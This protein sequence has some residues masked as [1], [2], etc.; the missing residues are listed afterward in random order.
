[1]G[2]PKNYYG[3]AAAI[4]LISSNSFATTVALGP[5]QDVTLYEDST[6]QL[7]NGAGE[8]IFAG[9]VG[10]NTAGKLRRA[11]IKFDVSAIPASATITSV[12]LAMVSVQGNPPTQNSLHRVF[13]SWGEGTS[14]AGGNEGGGTTA[15]LNDATWTSR[16]FGTP[17]NWATPGGDFTAAATT[18][19]TVAS[20]GTTTWSGGTIVNDVQ[21]WVAG[22]ATNFGWLL[23]GDETVMSTTMRYD[24]RQNSTVASRPVLTVIYTPVGAICDWER[25]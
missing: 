23:Q 11:L 8:G 9:R 7:A 17:L 19:A 22:P 21:S 1:M 14:H 2:C 13:A 24:S 12:S 6:G 25:Y 10:T 5:S 20:L 3:I 4:A 16:F 15:Q 18:T